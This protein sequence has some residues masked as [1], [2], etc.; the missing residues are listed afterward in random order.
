MLQDGC[1][2]GRPAKIPATHN[3][4]GWPL[5]VEKPAHLPFS[6]EGQYR[7]PLPE[8]LAVVKFFPLLLEGGAPVAPREDRAGM[9]AL[10]FKKISEALQGVIIDCEVHSAVPAPAEDSNPRQHFSST[11]E[12]IFLLS[13]SKIAAFCLSVKPRPFFLPYAGHG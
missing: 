2:H 4:K 11:Q 7:S 5:G 8:P 13:M 10:P 12:G 1:G 9:P 6:A 3:E